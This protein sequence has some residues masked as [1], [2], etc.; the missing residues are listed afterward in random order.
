MLNWN[1][2]WSMPWNDA[3]FDQFNTSTFKWKDEK[4]I[5]LRFIGELISNRK[6]SM[7]WNVTWYHQIYTS[8]QPNEFHAKDWTLWIALQSLQ[9]SQTNYQPELDTSSQTNAKGIHFCQEMIWALI[10]SWTWTDSSPCVSKTRT[11][12]HYCWTT[13]SKLSAQLGMLV[14]PK[15]FVQ[16]FQTRF[17]TLSNRAHTIW[18]SKRGRN[19]LPF[20]SQKYWL[21][22]DGWRALCLWCWSKIQ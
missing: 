16:C 17:F 5:S 21:V 7:P 3:R 9:Q 14:M 2:E 12:K 11:W 13:S 4:V 20:K 15:A 19:W 6:W 10:G 1:R 18:Y 22:L 8:G